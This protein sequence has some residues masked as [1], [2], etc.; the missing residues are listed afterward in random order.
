M[1]KSD[2]PRLIFSFLESNSF[3]STSERKKQDTKALIALFFP[4]ERWLTSEEVRLVRRERRV[5][6]RTGSDNKRELCFS[7]YLDGIIVR[8]FDERR[9]LSST[10]KKKN[11]RRRPEATLARLGPG[12]P[13]HRFQRPPRVFPH[14]LLPGRR[15]ELQEEGRKRRKRRPRPRRRRRRW[16]RRRRRTRPWG[17]P[18]A[19]RRHVL[20]AKRQPSCWRG[21]LRRGLRVMAFAKLKR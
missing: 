11:R 8:S 21:L 5:S 17:L 4:F 10:S 6:Y 18:P 19:R 3:D 14:Y 13:P 2:L 20:A 16:S 9:N 1:P 7:L 15:G 12:L